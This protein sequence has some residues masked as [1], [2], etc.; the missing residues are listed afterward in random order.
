MLA[1]IRAE[2]RGTILFL[3][4]RSL[5][6]ASSASRQSQDSLTPEDQEQFADQ[7]AGIAVEMLARA[8]EDGYFRKN[9]GRVADLTRTDDFNPLRRHP[10]F[11]ALLSKL[12]ATE[13]SSVK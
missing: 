9:P 12:A 8:R 13:P 2:Q 5:A 7:Y 4:A 10:D 11:K 3:L 1:G 6:L